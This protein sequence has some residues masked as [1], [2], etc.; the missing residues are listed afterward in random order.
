V[1]SPHAL[2]GYKGWTIRK[3]MQGVGKN[4]KKFM[5]GRVTKR[6]KLCKGEVKKKNPAE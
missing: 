6:K 3:V 4:K 1:H 2:R 5:Q